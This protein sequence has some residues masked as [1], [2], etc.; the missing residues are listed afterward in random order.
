MIY[1]PDPEF[2]P[3]T[4]WTDEGIEVRYV[5]SRMKSICVDFH[6]IEDGEAAVEALI[7]LGEV[8]QRVGCL[9]KVTDLGSTR[10]YYFLPELLVASL[11]RFVHGK[12][13][14]RQCFGFL[15]NVMEGSRGRHRKK[16]V[17]S[18]D[19]TWRP[20]VLRLLGKGQLE[21]GEA[22]E[23]CWSAMGLNDD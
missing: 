6:C 2:S 10:R 7:R 17:L 18:N 22:L 5:F 12:E 20:P 1:P 16:H 4:L 23:E 8:F 9:A 15:R 13:D 11:R 21:Y 3:S 14:D 19:K